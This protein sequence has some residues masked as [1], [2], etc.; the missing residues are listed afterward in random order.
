MFNRVWT[1]VFWVVEALVFI[2]SWLHD[3]TVRASIERAI[4][5]VVS[6]MVTLG[7]EASFSMF[8]WCFF[9]G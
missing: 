6:K 8:C 4:F 5:S 2:M 7:A 1:G 3:M 9:E